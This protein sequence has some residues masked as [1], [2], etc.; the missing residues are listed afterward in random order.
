MKRFTSNLV[1]GAIV[2]VL[3]AGMWSS[4]QQ[5]A[6]AA[7][8]PDRINLQGVLRD[9][10]GVP[11]DTTM[12][13]P[14]GMAAGYWDS[15]GTGCPASGGTLLMDETHASVTV[16]DGLFNV[17]L[18]SGTVTPG[19]AGS[20]GEAIRSNAEIWVEIEVEGEALC[21]RIRLDASAYAHLAGGLNTTDPVRIGTA[22]ISN[23]AT[24]TLIQ[25]GDQNTD[26][27][28]LYAGNN[29]G[30][31]RIRIL[32]GDLMELRAGNGSFTFRNGTTNF[33]IMALSPEGNLQIDGDLTVSGGDLVGLNDLTVGGAVTV[34]GDLTLSDGSV[35]N[36]ARPDPG[37]FDYA[38]RYV[39]CGNG[40]V[41]DTVTG[42]IWLQNADCFG[43]LDWVEASEATAGLG[44]GQCGLTD[45]SAPGDWRLPTEEEW[46]LIITRGQDNGCGDP[47]VP[48]VEG[49]GCC[50]TGTCAFAGV[51]SDDYWSSRTFEV[52]PNQAF[53]GALGFGVVSANFKIFSSYVW[54]VRV[55]P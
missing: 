16:T 22:S 4:P 2:T 23:D 36:A 20:L 29:F 7:T 5:A 46:S 45:G 31:G 35:L 34:D 37:C 3:A 42:L 44:D 14:L 26:D 10:G 12:G 49:T 19:T 41:T 55:G 30:D 28:L 54:P 25:A 48:D 17:A 1:R 40:T 39:D 15:E 33:E 6:T 21:P 13:T 24:Q 53:T 52:A 51:Q 8:A 43:L 50:A 32:G 9:A 11:I 38:N 27:L 47:Y 18:G